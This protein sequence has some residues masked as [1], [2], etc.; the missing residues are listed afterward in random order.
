MTSDTAPAPA[1]PAKR[2]RLTA[3]AADL[4]VAVATAL[5]NPAPAEHGWVDAAGFRWATQSW[6]DP[7]DPPVLLI[8]G[9]TSNADT[10]WRV[11]PALAAAGYRIVAL[12]LPGHG[13]T[14]PWSGQH[15][16]ADIAAEVIDFVR[17]AGLDRPN[18]AVV[19]HSLGGMITAHLSIAGL[20]P[21]VLV[22]LDPPTMT[23]AEFEVYVQDPSERLYASVDEATAAVRQANPGW[24]D[25]DVAAK[26]SGLTQ[27]DPD[28]VLAVLL[29]NGDWDSGLAALRDKRAAGLPVW[30]IRGEVEAGCLVPDFAV[31]AIEAQL[32]ADHVITIRDAPH[33]PQRTH[34]EAT[35][36]A[37]LRAL[38][39]SATQRQSTRGLRPSPRPTGFGG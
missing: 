9:V 2:A 25:G 21:R 22:L 36:V 7:G 10:W 19:G 30:F 26:A 32:G 3:T 8:H 5:A 12:E 38:G 13:R 6:G 4:P 34:P 20:R 11:G 31:P 17:A 27:F 24:S 33:S 28:A 14:H 15:R 37:L 1:R 35:L 18:L 39:P 29:K 23:V 16:F